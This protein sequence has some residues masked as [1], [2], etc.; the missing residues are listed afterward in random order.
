MMP[1]TAREPT[2]SPPLALS[3]AQFHQ[4][5]SEL[6]SLSFPLLDFEKSENAKTH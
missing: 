5:T 4:K 1:N 2:A 6:F 3:P